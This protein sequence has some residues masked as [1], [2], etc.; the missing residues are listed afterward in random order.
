MSHTKYYFCATVEK[1]HDVQI[2]LH[3]PFTVIV[4]RLMVT[5][6]SHRNT[7]IVFGAFPFTSQHIRGLLE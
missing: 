5:N 1:I 7:D 6:A 3:E 4:Y 2:T